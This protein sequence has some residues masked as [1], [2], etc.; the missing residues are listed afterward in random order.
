MK[1][2]SNKS[3]VTSILL[4]LPE[5]SIFFYSKYAFEESF[6]TSIYSKKQLKEI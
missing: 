6:E 2:V 4:P 5:R 1:F 3:R